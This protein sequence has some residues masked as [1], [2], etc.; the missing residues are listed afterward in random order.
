MKIKSLIL[1]LIAPLILTG[2]QNAD[3][4]LGDIKIG[5]VLPEIPYA[6]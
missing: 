4:D 6:D 1:F 2:C 3:I 5:L